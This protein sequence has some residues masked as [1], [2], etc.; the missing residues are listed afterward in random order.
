M[1][2]SE[3]L[4]AGAGP[5]GT[6]AALALAEQ[7]VDVILCEAASECAPDLRASTFH[8]PTVEML[9]RPGVAAP[10]LA[11]GLKAPVYHFRERRS[12]EVVAFDLG[13]LADVTPCPF[14]LQC[15]QH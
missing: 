12:G 13:E 15:E 14:R 2:R 3:V 1:E 5:V 10:L 8:P 9:D 4:V 6:F 7:G 11:R